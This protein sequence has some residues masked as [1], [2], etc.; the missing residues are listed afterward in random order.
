MQI[1]PKRTSA[2]PYIINLCCTSLRFIECTILRAVF[3]RAPTSFTLECADSIFSRFLPSSSVI[4]N[5]TSSVSW[6]TR[7]ALPSRSFWSS[8]K[9]FAFSSRCRCSADAPCWGWIPGRG[10]EAG[11]GGL[12][13][14]GSVWHRLFQGMGS[15]AVAVAVGKGA[16]K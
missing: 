8:S 15:M 6:M 10:R 3:V 4:S 14:L 1:A 13:F 16:G 5:A 7:R 11:F 12:Y 9:S 2:S